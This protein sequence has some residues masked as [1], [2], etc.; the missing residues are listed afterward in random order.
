MVNVPPVLGV[1]AAEAADA[2]LDAGA[3]VGSGALLD[4]T[5]LD[6]ALLDAGA[7]LDAALLDAGALVGSGALL[8]DATLDAGALLAGA[9]VGSGVGAEQA[10]TSNAM[11]STTTKSTFFIYSSLRFGKRK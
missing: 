4:A 2:L 10:A 3:F 11:A 9:L 6:A 7:L 8:L 5:L 1:T